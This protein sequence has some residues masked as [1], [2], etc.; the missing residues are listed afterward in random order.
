LLSLAENS[1]TKKLAKH[2]ACSPILESNPTYTDSELTAAV[3][4]IS[5]IVI[6][7]SGSSSSSQNPGDDGLDDYMEVCMITSNTDINDEYQP[8]V[9]DVRRKLMTSRS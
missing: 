9:L 7:S 5:R 2:S 6:G 8:I 1:V 3:C 4:S